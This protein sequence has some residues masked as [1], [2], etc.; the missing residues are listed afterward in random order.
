MIAFGMVTKPK[1]PQSKAQ[2]QANAR[3]SAGMGTPKAS[4]RSKSMAEM[5]SK[6]TGM[7]CGR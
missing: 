3:F 6:A 2:R 4:D 1:R 5:L 7:R